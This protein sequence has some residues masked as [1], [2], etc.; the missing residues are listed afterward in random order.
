MMKNKK[1]VEYHV[2][3]TSKNGSSF[4][5]YGVDSLKR[6]AKWVND[7][8][9]EGDSIAVYEVKDITKD[10]WWEMYRKDFNLP[11]EEVEEAK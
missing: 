5:V 2:R 8:K 1:S 4:T 9:Q 10:V 3:G 11:Y 6:A 7:F